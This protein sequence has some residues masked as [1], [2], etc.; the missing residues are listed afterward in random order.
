MDV[1][2]DYFARFVDNLPE[3]GELIRE[4]LKG[5]EDYFHLFVD[6]DFIVE[7]RIIEDFRVLDEMYKVEH[8]I[9]RALHCSHCDEWYNDGYVE[10]CSPTLNLVYTV[11]NRILHPMTCSG[12]LNERFCLEDAVDFLVDHQWSAYEKSKRPWKP[13][14]TYA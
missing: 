10:I 9:D 2:A 6:L 14:K 12:D 3:L 7:D 1:K 4:R 8:D 11:D 13:S 5:T